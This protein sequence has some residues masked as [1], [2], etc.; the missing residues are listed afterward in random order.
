MVSGMGLFGDF[1]GIL[2]RCMGLYTF[3][4]G[5]IVL[6]SVYIAFNG[7]GTSLTCTR[8]FRSPPRKPPLPRTTEAP[9]EG[10]NTCR[11]FSQDGLARHVVKR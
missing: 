6:Y 9:Q 3:I 2:W 4:L 8:V 11:D 1:I 5:Y 7:L 10:S